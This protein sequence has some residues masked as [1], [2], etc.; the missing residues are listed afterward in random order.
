MTAMMI[1][2]HKQELDKALA[3][4]NYEE[5]K[6]RLEDLTYF[7]NEYKAETGKEYELKETSIETIKSLLRM[8]EEAAR[9]ERIA[10]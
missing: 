3:N 10:E 4:G 1:R 5:A 8:D 6:R 2:M 9:L 7:M